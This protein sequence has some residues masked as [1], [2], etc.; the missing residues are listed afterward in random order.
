M[1]VNFGWSYPPG[2]TGNEYEIAGPDY[3]Q[4]IEEMCPICGNKLVQQGYRYHHWVVC[5]NCDY[6]Q[7]IEIAEK[8]G[9]DPRI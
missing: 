8:Y 2:I 4:E 9:D 1:S 6:Q 3:G 7:D 5:S